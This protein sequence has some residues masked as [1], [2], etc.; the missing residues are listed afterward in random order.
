M[1]KRPTKSTPRA[2]PVKLGR[3]IMRDAV[4]VVHY[5]PAM[6]D[7]SEVW[8]GWVD[9]AYLHMTI[10]HEPEWGRM[11]V[12]ALH[13]VVELGLM[14]NDAAFSPA[15]SLRREDLGRYR[16][17]FDHDVLTRVCNH[18]GDMLAYLLPDLEKAWKKHRAKP[19]KGSR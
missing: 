7:G 4:I 17:M 5:D 19:G 8:N 9:G 16:Y 12:S 13:E 1:T 10:G 11:V 14:L 18:A 2:G 3:Y 6:T 15:D